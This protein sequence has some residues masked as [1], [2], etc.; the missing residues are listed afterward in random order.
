M[1]FLAQQYIA[2]E[3]AYERINVLRS[4]PLHKCLPKAAIANAHVVS[5]SDGRKNTRLFLHLQLAH[6]VP[7]VIEGLESIIGIHMRKDGSAAYA[8]ITFAGEGVEVG[9]VPLPINLR[10]D[11]DQPEYGDE[12]VYQMVSTFVRLALR[13]R[14]FIVIEDLSYLTQETDASREVNRQNFALPIK[15]VQRVLTDKAML[16]GLPAPHITRGVPWSNACA[17]CGHHLR[18]GD[19]QIHQEAHACPNCHPDDFIGVPVLLDAA[20]LAYNLPGEERLQ[21][22]PDVVADMFARRIVWWDD[23]RLCSRQPVARWLHQANQG[24]LPD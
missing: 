1:R 19:V 22:T 14:A 6:E 15:R 2:Q 9:D 21:L 18:S 12:Y 3:I 11:P 17:E 20:A 23:P 24:Y 8:V 16:A 7:P 10:I 5:Q 4:T 13:H